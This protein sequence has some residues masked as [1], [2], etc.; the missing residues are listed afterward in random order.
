[1]YNL[2]ERHQEFKD[3]MSKDSFYFDK[4]N[5]DI[6]LIKREAIAKVITKRIVEGNLEGDTKEQVSRLQ[7]WWERVMLFFRKMM[8]RVETDPFVEASYIMMNNSLEQTL[9][10]DPSNVV[11]SGT[12]YQDNIL[13]AIDAKL[14]E[15]EGYWETE[16][17]VI[18]DISDKDLKN[19]LLKLPVKIKQ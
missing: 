12:F 3:M 10:A 9:K 7:R 1:M 5:G 17:I 15:Q 6:D 13:G 14:K 2:I 11:L 8:G 4:Y 18:D 19:I 16:E